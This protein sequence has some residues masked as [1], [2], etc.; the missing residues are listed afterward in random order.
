MTRTWLN[1]TLAYAAGFIDGE[2]H[3]GIG[4]SWPKPNRIASHDLRLSA[5]NTHK[6]VCTWL[7]LQFGGTV[8]RKKRQSERWR[9]CWLWAIRGN[10]RVPKVLSALRPWLK[11][12]S[13]QAWLALEYSAQRKD[14]RGYELTLEEESVRDGYQQAIQYCNQGAVG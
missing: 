2:G 10:E 6:G 9:P 3:I 4:K 12:K 1:E 8:Y 5:T 7:Q 13:T 14:H 11:V